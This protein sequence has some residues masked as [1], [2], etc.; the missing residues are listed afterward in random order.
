MTALFV[1]GTGTGVGKTW[2]T[3][4][5]IR[6]A[7]AAG[8]PVEALK[9]VISG[10]DPHDAAESDSGHLLAA[11]GRPIDERT[12]A[13]ISPW[14]FAA[15]L[16]PDMA[17]ARE[18]R[19]VDFDALVE[20]C[21]RRIAEAEGLLLIEGVGGAMVPLD[22]GHTV[23]DWIAALGIPAVVV[24]GSYLG[25]ISHSLTTLDSLAVAGIEAK[26]L[27]ISESESNPVPLAETAAALARFTAVPILT[28]G[29]DE[30]ADSGSSLLKGLLR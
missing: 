26:A 3:A 30:E 4:R 27:V 29:R 5:L 15:P 19:A 25:T 14:R 22:G 20:L 12:L 23:R 10:F 2:I 13:T 1:T 6:E 16:S 9:P 21:R 8:M 17:A 28:A 7:R 11:L 18:G 24:A